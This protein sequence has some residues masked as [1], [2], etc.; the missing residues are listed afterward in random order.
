MLDEP[1]SPLLEPVLLSLEKY[2]E[3]L[4]DELDDEEDEDERQLPLPLRE[5]ERLQFWLV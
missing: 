5:E 1:W 4:D 2:C 3:E